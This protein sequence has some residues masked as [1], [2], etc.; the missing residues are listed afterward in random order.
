M[1]LPKEFEGV[2]HPLS[3][4]SPTVGNPRS[5]EWSFAPDTRK[6]AVSRA[7]SCWLEKLFAYG[8]VQAL[9]VMAPPGPRL[10]QLFVPT[11]L[12][13]QYEVVFGVPTIVSFA[14]FR[15]WS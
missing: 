3:A 1:L 13:M 14:V 5:R 10:Y 11:V 9:V 12:E 4:H 2:A 15:A 7:L 6:G 8:P